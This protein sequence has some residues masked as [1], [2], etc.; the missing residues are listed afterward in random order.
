MPA[1]HRVGSGAGKYDRHLVELLVVAVGLLVVFLVRIR[2]EPRRIGNGVF[3]VLGLLF[4]AAWP[5]TS[6]SE[7]TRDLVLTVAILLSPLFAIVVAVFFIANGYLMLRREGKRL[8]NAL[9]LVAGIGILTLFGGVVAAVVT[10]VNSDDDETWLVVALGSV[11]LL[12]GYAGFTFTVFL[13]YSVIY[14][15]IPQSPGH[16][17]IVVLGAS[18]RDGRVRPLLASRLDRAVESYRREAAAGHR[19]VVVTCGGQ[20]PDEPAPEAR[21]MADYLR[22]QGIPDTALIEEDRSTSTRQNL[23]LA[24]ILLAEQGLNERLLVIT[25]NYHVLRTAILTR[26]LNLH[27]DVRGAKTARYYLPNAF[28]R[29]FVALLAQY[30]LTNAVAAGAIAAIFPL[31]ALYG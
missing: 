19:P 21:V 6:S 28:L 1:G 30:R 5:L 3:L 13:I 31:L 24:A 27:A 26:R 4:L 29:E 20:G 22:Q 25:S 15:R 9:S 7:E 11:V 16:N 14:G 17:A 23:Q 10:A 18:V 2:R 12:A 8:A